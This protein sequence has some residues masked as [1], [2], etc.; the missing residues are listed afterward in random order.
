MSIEYIILASSWIILAILLLIFV[1]KSRIR[2]ANVILMFKQVM[3]WLLGSIVVQ[4]HLIEYPV[5]LF[6][7]ALRTSFTFEFFVYPSLCVFFNLYYP[8]DKGLFR[9]FVHY[10][11]YTTGI[12][13]FEVILETYTNNIRYINWT[14]YYTWITIF[15]TF[16]LSRFYYTWFFKNHPRA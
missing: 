7:Y 9:R 1:P 11:I 12:T 3:T 2:E 13:V 10:F 14:W 16:L 5:R 8:E 4:L 15:I 6:P